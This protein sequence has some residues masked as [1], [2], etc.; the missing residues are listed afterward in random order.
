MPNQ[1]DFPMDT[2]TT[3]AKPTGFQKTS[4]SL[5]FGE[6]AQKGVAQTKQAYERMSAATVEAADLMETSC[7]T[8]LNGARD[9]NNKFME[10]AHANTNAA[11]DFVQE[12]YGVKSPSEFM[13][14]ATEHARTQT[15]AL[16][17]QTKEL[18]A[19]A[20]KVALATT[21]PL[22]AGVAK[23]FNQAA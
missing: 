8:A 21:E 3:T 18:A 7:S 15:T 4:E 12:L 17:E 20:Q 11:F 14:L 22:K 16:T 2:K 1:E 6:I 23:A 9:Y 5:A 19:L 10:F 13:E